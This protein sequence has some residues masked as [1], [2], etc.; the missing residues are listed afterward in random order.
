MHRVELELIHGFVRERDILIFIAAIINNSFF[1]IRNYY[2]HENK[3][4]NTFFYECVDHKKE[5][6]V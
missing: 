1:E 2:T 4:T 3:F 5:S 6:Q